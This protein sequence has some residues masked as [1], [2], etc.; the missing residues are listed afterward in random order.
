VSTETP[1]PIE[2]LLAQ[3]TWVRQVARA[4]VA[5]EA[6]ADDLEQEVWLRAL[7][8]RPRD[9][10]AVRSWF[11]AV[12]RHKARDLWRGRTRRQRAEEA[13][14][15][16]SASIP[17]VDLVAEA[18]AH[19]RVV[20]A[21]MALDEPYRTTIVLR[22]F[23]ELAVAEVARRTGVP[24]ETARTRLRRGLALLRDRFD[25][26][27]GGKRS[28]WVAAVLPLT[29]RATRKIR[30][31]APV[32]PVA[33]SILVAAALTVTVA[34]VVARSPVVTPS[35][36][37]T[38]TA[39]TE[40]WRTAAASAPRPPRRVDIVEGVDTDDGVVA[41]IGDRRQQ[42]VA[43]VATSL[44]K[45]STSAAGVAGDALAAALTVAHDP[46]EADEAKLTSTIAALRGFAAAGVIEGQCHVEIGRCLFRLGRLAEARESLEAG[47]DIGG[48]LDF[49]RS[50]AW[51]RLGCIADLDGRRDEAVAHYRRVLA[52]PDA[53]NLPF[54][55]S[56]AALF[57]DRPY[58]GYA[59]DR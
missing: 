58:A 44:A 14:P 53:P 11:R 1:V 51:L 13:M 39:T 49:T 3:R 38:A 29:R 17:T 23:H 47:L 7:E 54:Q 19:R 57:I 31:V 2:T 41:P 26:E 15:V 8:H 20:D 6:V 55:K 16:P 52:L 50:W 42:H 22:Y 36:G 25:R 28:A 27:S 45:T 12:L 32:V 5:D 33:A 35:G 10:G 43:D 40:S 30:P 37:P 59:V 34:V 4:L 46:G 9:D 48:F 21:V 56:R 18:D 24:R